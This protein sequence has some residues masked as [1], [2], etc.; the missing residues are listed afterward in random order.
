MMAL[1]P[2]VKALLILLHAADADVLAVS[3]TAKLPRLAGP[4][5]GKR[6][7][8]VIQTLSMAQR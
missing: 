2:K 4:P 6:C 8:L 5:K 1:N 3:L 7:P